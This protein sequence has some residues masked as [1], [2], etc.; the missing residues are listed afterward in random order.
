MQQATIIG[1][2]G[3]NAILQSGNGSEYVTFSVAVSEK[4][5]N[6][7]GQEVEQTDWWSCITRQKNL[8][9]YLTKGTKVFCQG[10]I[11]PNLYKD[12]NNQYKAG[13]RLSCNLIELLSSKKEGEKNQESV[14]NQIGEILPGNAQT[15]A[16]DDLPF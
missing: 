3:Q 8:V 6:S 4:Y 9:Q 16:N 13:L 14:D 12:R 5:T 7:D 1:H 10:K 15:P 2:I 11:K